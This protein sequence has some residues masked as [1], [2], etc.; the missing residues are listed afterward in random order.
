MLDDKE[1]EIVEVELE[2]EEGS[3]IVDENEEADK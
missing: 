2:I 3:E 1:D